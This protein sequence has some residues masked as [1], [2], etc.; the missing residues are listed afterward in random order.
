MHKKC[1]RTNLLSVVLQ[2]YT[3]F[4]RVLAKCILEGICVPIKFCTA[5]HAFLLQQE[6]PCTN[7][8][9]ALAL[10]A[11]FDPVEAQSLRQTLHALLASPQADLGVTYG[12]L[13]GNDDETP[14]T[15]ANVD[16]VLCI[17]VSDQWHRATQLACP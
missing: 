3:A 4:G 2:E 8:T 14:L 10:M 17:K 11:E 15:A 12:M 6:T 5:L 7:A 16:A 9:L 1:Y 13:L